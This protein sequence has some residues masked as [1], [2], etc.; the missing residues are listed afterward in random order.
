VP[1]ATILYSNEHGRGSRP[2]V[3]Q[4]EMTAMNNKPLYHLLVTLIMAYLR[5]IMPSWDGN[6]EAPKMLLAYFIRQ[7]W[8][9]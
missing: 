8:P 6:T 7:I 2:L 1:H 4:V 5:M 3:I 9:A